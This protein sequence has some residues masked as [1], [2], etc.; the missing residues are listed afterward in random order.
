MRFI[1]VCVSILIRT[2]TNFVMP[3]PFTEVLSHFENFL[4]AYIHSILYLRTIYPQTT[5]VQARLHNTAVHQSRHPDV[6]SYIQSV[7][8]A[9]H[10][11]LLTNAVARIGVVL[12]CLEGEADGEGSTQVV[13]RYVLDVNAFPAVA[14]INRKREAYMEERDPLSPV[15][16]FTSDTQE[17]MVLKPPE[18]SKASSA[19]LDEH[20]P[21]D[22]SEQFRATFIELTTH[23]SRL[24]CL[25]KST[26]WQIYMELKAENDVSIQYPQ[27]WGPVQL[28]AEVAET[29]DE[30]LMIYPVRE[31]IYEALV[32]E[33][34]IEVYKVEKENAPQ[35]S[36]KKCESIL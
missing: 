3:T 6:C 9:I 8:S 4:L 20:T 22:L 34:W 32:F 10:A 15:S 31:A 17:S 23:C 16:S 27:S 30:R 14:S 24:R 25:P 29:E 36:H 13:E 2:H 35:S 12:Y 5:F 1:L 7:A 26:T 11:E 18:P 33:A 19:P 28:P 21:P